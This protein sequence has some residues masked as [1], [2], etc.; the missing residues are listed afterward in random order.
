MREGVTPASTT[1]EPDFDPL[2]YHLCAQSV[3]F[4]PAFQNLAWAQEKTGTFAQDGRTRLDNE[5]LIPLC[6]ESH[7]L[8]SLWSIA[9]RTNTMKMLPSSQVAEDL[10]Y[11]SYLGFAIPDP[12]FGSLG[13]KP[14]CGAAILHRHY[15]AVGYDIR[16]LK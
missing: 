13:Q 7:H 15:S 10:D 16:F 2:P 8:A 6:L 3:L 5:F 4:G 12:S 1:I 11:R 14:V 9:R